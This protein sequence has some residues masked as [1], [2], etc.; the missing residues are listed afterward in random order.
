M[1]KIVN[2]VV[3]T[4]KKLPEPGKK[5]GSFWEFMKGQL[6][7]ESTWDEKHLKVIEK[8]IDNHLTKL[9]RK[10]LTEMWKITDKGWEKFEA[11]KKVEVKEMKEDLNDELLGQVMDRMDDNYSSRDPYYIQHDAPLYSEEKAGD[12]DFDE[13]AE[14]DEIEDEDID[15]EDNNLLDD[16][17][18]EDGEDTRF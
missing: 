12:K 18:F 8:E 4:L 16:E 15:L 6:A 9:D 13:D 14:P 5:S 17:E 7:E 11:E 10:D 3:T 2:D 1:K